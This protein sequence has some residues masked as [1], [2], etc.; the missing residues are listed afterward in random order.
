[1]SRLLETAREYRARLLAG[2]ADAQYWMAKAYDNITE[3]IEARIDALYAQRA[4]A[5]KQGRSV[6]VGWLY[7]EERLKTLLAQA[8][9]EY[10]RFAQSAAQSVVGGQQLAFNLAG[11]ASQASIGVGFNRLPYGAI[12]QF[13]GAASDGSPLSDL[14]RNHWSGAAEQIKGI[15]VTGIGNGF[16]PRLVARRIREVTDTGKTRAQ[17]VVRTEMLRAY[18]ESSRAIYQENADVVS[19]W[20]WVASLSRRTCAACLAMHGTVHELSEAMAAHV[21]CRCVKAPLLDGETMEAFKTGAEWFA[22]Q[23]TETMQAVLGIQGAEAYRSGSV[24]LS[25][26]VGVQKSERW[27]VSYV[28]VGL[29]AAQAKANM[30]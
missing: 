10:N 3:S 26:F 29:N 5:Q 7:R 17:A 13:V 21:N 15:L 14:F 18:R 20:I 2:E 24:G 9:E 19:G 1:M 28:Q 12:E 25:D 4:E 6:G 16:S 23:D 8:Q 27:G 22:E 30:Q 11:E